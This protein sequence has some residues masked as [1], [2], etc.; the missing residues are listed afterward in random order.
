MRF[1]WATRT[2]VGRLRDHNEDAVWPTGIGD[3]EEVALVGVADGMGGHAGGE[4]ASAVALET[5]IAA[6]GD[7]AMRI[8][9]ANLA[10]LDA[11]RERPRLAGMGTTLILAEFGPGGEAHFGHVGDSRAYRFRAGDLSQ[12][13]TDHS[14]VAEMIAAGKMTADEAET[15]PYRS[16]LTRAVG[17]DK[18]VEVDTFTVDLEPGDLILLCSDGLTTMLSDAEVGAILHSGGDPVETVAKLV[19]AANSAGGVDNI[20]VALV[21]AAE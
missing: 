5:A 19:D 18:E 8:R 13:S 21:E 9:A 6:G 17:L 14:Y 11:A 12:V 16:V 10:V 2:D 4:V 15:H 7:P 20:T 3:W 1:R